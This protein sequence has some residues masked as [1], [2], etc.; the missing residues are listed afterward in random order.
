M[1]ISKFSIVYLSLFI[2]LFITNPVYSETG[3]QSKTFGKYKVYYSAFNSS[4]LSAPI[5]KQ[6]GITR[7]GTNGVINIAVHKTDGSNT[8]AVEAFVSGS[9]KNLLSQK[10]QLKFKKIDEGE[11][12]YYLATFQFSNQ[13]NLVFE[14]NMTPK[15]E[16]RRYSFKFQNQFYKD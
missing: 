5:A 12:I 2:A 3:E 16:K 4:M 8:T 9:V 14:I 11:A 7:S 13:D 15:D 10:T 6:Y 1:K